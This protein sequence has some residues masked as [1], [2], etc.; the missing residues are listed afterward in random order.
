MA[1]EESKIT[2]DG[3]ELCKKHPLVKRIYRTQSGQVRVKGGFMHLCP[4]DTPDT[5]GFTVD[6]RIIG[7]EYKTQKAFSEKN[8]G[9]SD[10]QINHL[11]DIIE[12]GG[13]AGIA[14]CNEHVKLILDGCPVGLEAHLSV[15]DDRE[16]L[17]F[18]VL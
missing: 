8:H 4:K 9:A 7:I 16:Q 5:T 14:C 10:G 11:L 3:V 12:A 2:K 6:G 1:S 18:D 17:S 15:S 13:L